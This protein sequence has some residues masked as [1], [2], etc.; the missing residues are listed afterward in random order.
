MPRF[1]YLLCVQKLLDAFQYSIGDAYAVL[2]IDKAIELR[3]QYSI[4][5]AP[6]GTVCAPINQCYYDFQYSIGDAGRTWRGRSRRLNCSAFNTPLETR[7]GQHR[8]NAFGVA[9]VLSILHWRC[10]KQRIMIVN[11]FSM[12]MFFQYSIGDALQPL[13][14]SA[15]VLARVAVQLSILHWRC[16][17][18]YEEFAA[19]VLRCFQYSIGDARAWKTAP[20]PAAPGTFNTPLEMPLDM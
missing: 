4:G 15:W 16:D 8:C 20:G 12:S 1:G 10:Q 2:P 11:A 6:S 18:E 5:D 19:A 17:A 7:K 14:H 3:F 13:R 9:G